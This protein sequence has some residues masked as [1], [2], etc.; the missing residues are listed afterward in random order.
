MLLQPQSGDIS[1]EK[2]EKRVEIHN[3]NVD[4]CLVSEDI[5]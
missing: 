3:A 4:A 1:V 2:N 5:F